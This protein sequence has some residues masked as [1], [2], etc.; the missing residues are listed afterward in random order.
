MDLSTMGAKLEE[1]HYKDRFAFETDFRLM[2]TNAKQYN[3]GGSYAHSEAISMETFFEKCEWSNN[4]VVF[5]T[6]QYGVS[7]WNR[8]NKTLE[9]ANK[10]AEPARDELPSIVVKQLPRKPPPRSTPVSTPAPP[11]AAEQPAPRPI[12]KLKVGGAQVK[13]TEKV[14]EKPVEKAVEKSAE[15]SK[16]PKF[17]VRKPKIPDEAP[18]PY[19]DDGSHDLLQ[20]VIAIEREKDEKRQRRMAESN[21]ESPPAK[22]S[23]SGPP[24][25][26][27]KPNVEDDED[28][29]LTF[30]TP[31]SRRDKPSMPP[32]ST[33]TPV[34][35]RPPAP[36]PKTAPAPPPK[37]KKKGPEPT[38][39]PAPVPEAP[40]IS[41]KGK[42]REVPS[43]QPTPSKP[44]AAATT[45]PLNEKKCRDVLRV[46]SKL[47]EYAIFSQPVDPIRDGCPT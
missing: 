30:A 42:E 13:P 11:L 35:E 1:G 19:V 37:P 6:K 24:G 8:I 32:S 25:K 41:V 44:R 34:P 33:S 4:Q 12:I 16:T 43:A 26:R 21:R 28:E 17:K 29:I 2:I 9:A 3:V 23:G 7:V 22:A 18:P 31:I 39:T 38:P 36:T 40:R 45:T 20:E 5:V 27:R 15:A 46:I 47:P 10:G 14:N